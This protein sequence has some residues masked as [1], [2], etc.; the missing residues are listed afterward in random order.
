VRKCPRARSSLPGQ[1]LDHR[2]RALQP[3]RRRPCTNPS[4]GSL[5]APCLARDL[6]HIHSRALGDDHEVACRLIRALNLARDLDYNLFRARALSV[7][8][9][10]ARADAR[11]LDQAL[12]DYT[13]SRHSLTAGMYEPRE[14]RRI[15]SWATGLLAAATRLLPAAD[16]ARYAEEYQSELWDIAQDGCG[17]VRQVRYALRQLICAAEMSG[18]LRSP[19]R[20]SPAP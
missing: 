1:H 18:A 16:R 19:R 17:P 10:V 11:N 12:V 2:H 5:R 9:N 8:R 15:G 7:S 3:V 13:A 20:R 6:R 14:A 4:K